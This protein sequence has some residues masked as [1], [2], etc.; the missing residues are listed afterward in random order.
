MPPTFV[1]GVTFNS[2][3]PSA[4][5]FAEM[6]LYFPNFSL[7]SNLQTLALAWATDSGTPVLTVQDDTSTTWTVGPTHFD[8]GN[9]YNLSTWYRAGAPAGIRKITITATGGTLS[10][11]HPMIREFYNVATSSPT[12]STNA[13]HANGSSASWGPGSQ[14]TTVNGDLIWTVAIDSAGFGP[15]SAFTPSG[16]G[17][18]LIGADLRQGMADQMMIQTTAGAISPVITSAASHP[19]IACSIAFKAAVAGTAPT[20]NPRIIQITWVNWKAA[21]GTTLPQQFPCRGDTIAVGWVGASSGGGIRAM[22]AISDTNGNSYTLTTGA[23]NGP[24]GYAQWGYDLGA[25][26]SNNNV[27]TVTSLADNFS[28]AVIYDISAPGCVFDQV[29]AAEGLQVDAGDLTTVSVSPAG[30]NWLVLVAVGINN[31]TLRDATLN[32][33]PWTDTEDGGGNELHEDNGWG[34]LNSPPDA[35]LITFTWTG[36]NVGAGDGVQDWGAEAIAFS[37]GRPIP[38]PRTFA[39]QQRMA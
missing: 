37:R 34:H 18:E 13:W 36:S 38:G 20:A 1:Q 16:A 5:A 12:D 28:T 30:T 23:G 27:V 17:A 19:F 2:T 10:F 11:G 24:S 9:T 3:G 26:V 21:S 22:S 29:Q 15:Y 33:N 4:S 6:E 32:D 14:T 7:A 39:F 8:A 31:G 35:G 25:T